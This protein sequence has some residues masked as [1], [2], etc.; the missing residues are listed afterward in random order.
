MKPFVT[1]L[2]HVA[3]KIRD[4]IAGSGAPALTVVPRCPPRIPSIFRRMPSGPPS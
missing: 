3:I 4:Q 1:G 2:F